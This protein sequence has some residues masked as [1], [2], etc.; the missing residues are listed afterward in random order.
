MPKFYVVS[1]IHGFADEMIEA[2]DEAGFDTNDEDSWLIS[3][4]DVLDRG[5]QSQEVIDYLMG[6]PRSILL[7]GNH[8][9]LMQELIERE[10]PYS[11]DWHNGTAQSVIDLASDVNTF[12]NATIVANN[13]LKPYFNKTINYFET[14]NYIFCH[15]WIPLK[16]NNGFPQYHPSSNDSLSFDSNWRNASD[17]KWQDAQW[18]NPFELAE[19]GFLPDKTLVFGHF[20]TSWARYHFEN[21]SEWGKDADFSIYYG[22]G[23]IGID[24][25]TAYSGKINVL[26]LEDDFI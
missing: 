21:K 4:G 18:G 12:E 26:V 7:K 8:E 16:C 23:Y 14:K 19:Q 20:H 22:D 1:D 11:Y 6:L 2:L 25:C 15:S 10:F 3:L 5:P 24:T 17:L 13:K 9:V